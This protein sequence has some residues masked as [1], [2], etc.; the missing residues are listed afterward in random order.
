MF[1][2][3]GFDRRDGCGHERQCRRGREERCAVPSCP[4]ATPIWSLGGLIGASIGRLSDG[5]LS[6]CC[7]HAIVVTV[8]VSCD[9]SRLPGRSILADASASCGNHERKL[10]LPRDTAALA[11][12]HHGAFL[13]GARRCRSR[14]GCAL[15]ARMNSAPPSSFRASAFAA[16]SA[17]HG[18]DAL[19][20]RSRCATGSVP[21]MTLR[22]CTVTRSRRHGAGRL[23]LPMP[24]WRSLGFALDRHRHIQHGA[25]RLFGRRQYAGSCSRA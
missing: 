18:G 1:L 7:A 21:L 17:H 4:R 5:A 25:D 10:R 6:A 11:D 24:F 19:C 12:R 15:S 3:G 2:L 20:R 13:D 8:P 14:L 9:D 23:S 16:F 22:I